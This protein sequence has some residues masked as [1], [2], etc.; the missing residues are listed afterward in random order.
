MNGFLS[1]NIRI[2]QSF[3]CMNWTTNIAKNIA[4]N[5]MLRTIIYT[6]NLSAIRQKY[7][8][9]K[10]LW[11]WS[12]SSNIYFIFV[13]KLNQGND[14]TAKKWNRFSPQQYYR[15]IYWDASGNK[16]IFIYKGSTFSKWKFYQHFKCYCCTDF[17]CENVGTYFKR[18]VMIY[19]V[20]QLMVAFVSWKIILL[21]QSVT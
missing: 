7:R 16:S 9:S 10:R 20:S 8:L 12:D 2:Y 1:K 15:Y 19:W 14:V 18:Y 5:H 17:A 11:W 4:V 3:V 13:C 21:N 6:Q